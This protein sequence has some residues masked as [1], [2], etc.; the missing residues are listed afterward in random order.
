MLAA[1]GLGLV[2]GFTKNIQEEKAIRASEQ[3]SID[4]LNA[5]ITQAALTGGDNFSKANAALI[6][7]AVKAQ[8]DKLDARERI[9]IFG[10]AGPRISTDLSSIIP[11]LQEVDKAQE[12]MIKKKIG[13]F[14]FL[15]P[16]EYNDQVGTGRADVILYDAFADSVKNNPKA[17]ETHVQDTGERDVIVDELNRLTTS[18]LI[19][20]SKGAQGAPGEIKVGLS[21]LNNYDYFDNYLNI[22]S[23]QQF[24][25]NSEAFKGS[26]AAQD[27]FGKETLLSPELLLVPGSF[28]GDE[29]LRRLKEKGLNGDYAAFMFDPNA[30]ENPE[31]VFSVVKRAAEINGKST[32]QWFYDFVQQPEIADEE[33]LHTVLNKMATLTDMGVGKS[34]L[35]REENLALGKFLMEDADLKDNYVMQATVIAPFR[36]L[37]VNKVHQEMMNA[38]LMNEDFFSSKTFEQQFKSLYGYEVTQFRERYNA[39]ESARKKL[40]QYRSIVESKDTVSGGLT[41]WIVRNVGATIAAGGTVDQLFAAMGLDEINNQKDTTGFIRTFGDDLSKINQADVLRYI[42]ATDLARAEDSAGRLSDGDIMRNLQKLQGF[43]RTSISAELD[44]IDTVIQTLNDQFDNLR[45]LNS[46]AGKGDKLTRRDRELLSA[47]KVA[48]IARNEYLIQTGQRR[49]DDGQGTPLPTLEEFAEFTPVFVGEPTTVTVNEQERTFK[50]I[51][52]MGTATKPKY[53]GITEDNTVVLLTPDTIGQIVNSQAN[54]GNT[55][56]A[57]PDAGVTPIPN[58]NNSLVVTDTA[59][60]PG[61]IG[62]GGTYD[63]QTM[64]QSNTPVGSSNIMTLDQVIDKTGNANPSSR[65]TIDGKVYEQQADG[66]YRAAM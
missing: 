17:F 38:G 42:I 22:S 13:T 30:L 65:V 11:L 10:T 7:K 53:V 5:M 6:G 8:Q 3:Q 9:D 64:I 60:R 21:N 51:R 23:G 18:N 52:N 59:K 41:E 27:I 63:S 61:V 36:P 43:G 34:V 54:A 37:R 31:K 2:Q 4:S 56:A 44:Q 35:S 48:G 33:D 1:L 45:I 24:E 15:V 58:S 55:P 29:T 50:E 66:N 25:V 12:G 14:E 62:D 40:A 47:D 26:Q 28:Y 20:K 39:F 16:E 19:Y 57:A 46:I 49:Q 32:Q